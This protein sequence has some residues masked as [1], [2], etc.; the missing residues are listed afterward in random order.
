LVTAEKTSASLAAEEQLRKS[1]WG[2][3]R[4]PGK[5]G[6]V[7]WVILALVVVALLILIARL[8]PKSPEPTKL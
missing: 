5:G 1:S 6:V 8:L 4:A 7:F 3:N 2:E